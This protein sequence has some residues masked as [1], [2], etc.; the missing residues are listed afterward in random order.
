[1]HKQEMCIY[2]GRNTLEM[3]FILKAL[4]NTIT[5]RMANIFNMQRVILL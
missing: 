3:N 4:E 2:S 5:Y 1:M